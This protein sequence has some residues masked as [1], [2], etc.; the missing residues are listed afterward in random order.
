VSKLDDTD[1]VKTLILRFRD[2]ATGPGQTIER[3]Q[4]QI[5]KGGYVWWG[6]WH[7]ADEQAAVQLFVKLN[8]RAPFDVYLFDTGRKQLIRARCQKIVFSTDGK[9]IPSPEPPATPEYYRDQTY[10]AWLQLIE[11]EATPLQEDAVK[12]W[13]YL[14]VDDFFE[15]GSSKFERFYGK[16]IA[17]FE[18]LRQ[19]DRSIWFVRPAEA[20]DPSHSIL[21]TEESQPRPSNFPPDH[22]IREGT[23]IMWLSDI[24]VSQDHYRFPK[25]PLPDA[26]D[27]A[28]ALQLDLERLGQ[29]RLA[30]LFVSGDLT[31]RASNEEFDAV[32]DV[33]V[34]IQSWSKLRNYDLV[35]CPGNH[36]LVFSADP[37]KL[38]SPVTVTG[39]GSRAAFSSFYE[40]LF[41]LQPNQFISSGRRFLLGGAYP[42]EIIALNSSYLEQTPGLFQGFGF[43]G[44][45]QLADAAKQMGWTDDPGAGRP[46]RILMLHHHLVPVVY[47][48]SPIIGG[49]YSLALDAGAIL[50][51][52]VAHQ[53]DLVLHGHMHEPFRTRLDYPAGTGSA[54]YRTPLWIVGMGSSGVKAEHI[55]GQ[56]QAN[57]FG[58][59]RF[60]DGMLTVSVYKIHPSERRQDETAVFSVDIPFAFGGIR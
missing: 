13:T 38:D 37:A 21:L 47:S 16:R 51:W 33:L 20:T 60:H 58:I 30:G 29:T 1:Q 39:P 49:R 22:V 45:E 36:D 56:D 23:S 55:A 11:I 27:L 48:E 54:R 42:V 2:L 5:A 19:Q 6:W 18:E 52:A 40:Q 44:N 35:L 4:Q 17:S 41:Q 28:N 12:Q 32:R 8:S 3:H 9:R 10:F 31:W 57:T 59:L 50:R 7:K 14:R 24:H 53:V 25:Q 34:R 43:V 15:S 46:F 26:Q